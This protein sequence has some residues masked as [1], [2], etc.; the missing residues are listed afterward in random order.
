M[1]QLVLFSGILQ[2][3]LVSHIC[4]ISCGVLKQE[5]QT[6]SVMSF[7]FQENKRNVNLYIPQSTARES[8]IC[9]LGA[10][11]STA[12][13]CMDNEPH[14]SRGILFTSLSR[15]TDHF[16]PD[17]TMSCAPGRRC[18]RVSSVYHLVLEKCSGISRPAANLLGFVPHTY[19]PPHPSLPPPNQP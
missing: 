10:P 16:R 14:P 15:K 19:Q 5:R 11:W 8:I 13:G 7:P 2:L 17:H 18:E 3:G 4:D 12:N 6:S 9:F 1:L